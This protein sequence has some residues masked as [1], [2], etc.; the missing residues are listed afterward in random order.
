MTVLQIKRIR[1]A[2]TVKEVNKALDTMPTRI[3]NMYTET[4]ERVKT[5]P[6][7]RYRLGMRVLGW[8]SLTKRQLL[9][10]ELCHALAV[11]YEDGSDRP[12]QLD[13]DNLLQPKALVD[14]CAG[15][16]TI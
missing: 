15:L 3:F 10:D 16:V 6:E 11:E 9:V 2:V 8:M 5:Q 4:L 1:G 12:L 14:V 7:Q 13:P